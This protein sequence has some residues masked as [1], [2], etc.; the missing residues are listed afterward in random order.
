MCMFSKRSLENLSECHPDLQIIFKEVIKYVDCSILCG[1][2]GEKEQNEAFRKGKS[3]LKYPLSKHNTDQYSMAVDVVPYPV[4]WTNLQR[5]YY[6]SGFVKGMATALY[7]R[8]EIAHVVRWGGDWDGD[9]DF[10]DQRFHDF[11]HFELV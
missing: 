8:G 1:Y 6:L 5:F 4:D 11:P 9:N 10:K 7:E 3:K 2:R